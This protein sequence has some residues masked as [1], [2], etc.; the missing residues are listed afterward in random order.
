MT[1]KGIDYYLALPYKYA[2]Y[3]AEE[4]DDNTEKTE[5]P[6]KAVQRYP[7]QTDKLIQHSYYL[8]DK[9]QKAITIKTA[10][11]DFDK[12]GVVREA[13]KLYLADILEKI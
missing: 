11:G 2:L 4:G 12:S 8:T 5:Q 1:N 6:Q 10:E 9:L 13:L 3:P 7:E